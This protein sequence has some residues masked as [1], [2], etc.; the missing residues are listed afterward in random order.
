MPRAHGYTSIILAATVATYAAPAATPAAAQSNPYVVADSSFGELPNGRAYGATSAVDPAPDGL[1]IWVAERCGANSCIDRP[2]LATVFRFDLDGRRLAAFGQG[3]FAWPHGIDVDHDGNVWVTDAVGFG[4]QP[5]DLGHVVYKFSPDGELLLTLG[6]KGVAGAGRDTFNQPSDVL[7]APDGSIFVADGHGAGGNNRIVKLAPD[8]SYLMEWGSTGEADGEFRDPHGLAMDSRGRLFVADRANNRIQIF[9]QQGTH[10]AS[11]TQFGRP[12]GIHIDD[13]DVLYVADSE[14]NSRRNPGFRRGIYIGSAVSGEVRAFIPDPEPNPD[15][16]A[17]SG[18]EGVA[19]D[20]L[21]NVYGAEVGPRTLR[22]YV[23]R[24]KSRPVCPS[25][26]A[27]PTPRR[28]RSPPAAASRARSRA[29]RGPG[30]AARSGARAAPATV[31]PASAT[32]C[33]RRSPRAGS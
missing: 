21:G 12:S 18:A 6:T 19:A 23:S 27:G 29:G 20:A 16:S 14:S 8:G 11:W 3:L 31:R 4:E 13:D 10:L 17:T 5:A 9:D 2:E 25:A 15:E 24:E 26:P 7:V 33:A 30:P 32:P 22:K 28:R 1:S